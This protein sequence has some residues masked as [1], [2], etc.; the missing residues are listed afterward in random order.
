MYVKTKKVPAKKWSVPFPGTNNGN[1][2]IFA[3]AAAAVPSFSFQRYK[4][5]LLQPIAFEIEVAT[6]A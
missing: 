4:L 2:L 1:P 6:F 5:P 3:A